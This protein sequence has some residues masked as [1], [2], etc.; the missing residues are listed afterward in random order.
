MKGLSLL[1]RTYEFLF[2]VYIKF[3]E[4]KGALLAAGIAFFIF[5][6]LF[7]LLLFF[8]I[9]LSFF[10]E[11]ESAREQVL[12]FV[13]QNLPILADLIQ[14]TIEALIERRSSA[15]FIA[16]LGLLWAGTGLFGAL[17]VGL[18]AV[19]EVKE[20]RNLIQQRLIGVWVFFLIILLILV[21]F[22]ASTLASAFR[23]EVL[24]ALFPDEI[25]ALARTTITVILGLVSTFLLFLIVYRFV[26]NVKLTFASIWPGTLAAGLAWEV[27][28]YF[29]ALYLD[30]F[31]SQTYGLVY[32]SLATVI[33]VMFWLYIS[34][35]LLLIGAEINVAYRQRAKGGV[36]VFEPR[37]VSGEGI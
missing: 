19:Y 1:K 7:P 26:P 34:A 8:G 15:G 11:T 27:A 12:G 4:H 14:D 23:S 17:A 24:N 31:A 10:L 37:K 29:F 16:L 22:G 28:K 32:G 3:N 18:N 33:L 36:K 25:A 13:F 21:S 5:F 35:I 2:D 6:S 20:T 9:A 30:A